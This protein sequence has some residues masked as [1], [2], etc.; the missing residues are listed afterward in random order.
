M[1]TPE[2]H[3]AVPDWAREFPGA[4]TVC[5]RDGITLYMNDRAAATFAAGGGASLVGRSLIDCH[6]EPA[7]SKLK[8]LLRTA[9]TNTYTIEKA[10]V[11]KLIHQCPWFK[12]GEF[13]GL[14]ELSLVIPASM[15]HFVRKA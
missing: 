11:R 1:N 3:P 6:P 4:I 5:D 9:G 8:E 12:E 14:V 13:A 10:G 15:P 2:S 7:R